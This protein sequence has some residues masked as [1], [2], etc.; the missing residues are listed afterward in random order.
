[1]NSTEAVAAGS[2]RPAEHVFTALDGKTTALMGT[3]AR[4]YGT[5]RRLDDEESR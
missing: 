1:V 4:A 3:L 5:T 2:R